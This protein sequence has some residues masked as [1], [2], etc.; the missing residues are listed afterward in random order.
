MTNGNVALSL[1]LFVLEHTNRKFNDVNG[2]FSVFIFPQN[3][4]VIYLMCWYLMYAHRSSSI[5]GFD[6]IMGAQFEQTHRYDDVGWCRPAMLRLPAN[7][8]IWPTISNGNASYEAVY[9]INARLFAHSRLLN[10]SLSI[11][12][13]WEADT[14]IF[15]AIVDSWSALQ[16]FDKHGASYWIIRENTSYSLIWIV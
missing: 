7:Q 4:Y 2:P 3:F 15:V 12:M 14:C 8:P 6:N 1:V 9:L 11:W 16:S 13:Y 5:H 10:T